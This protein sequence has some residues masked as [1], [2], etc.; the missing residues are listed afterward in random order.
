[1]LNRFKLIGSDIID[2]LGDEDHILTYENVVEILNL[3]SDMLQ[4]LRE[5]NLSLNFVNKKQADFIKS[6]GYTLEQL[7]RFIDG[8]EDECEECP[9]KRSKE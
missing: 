4:K 2:T 5:D 3:Q 8:V 9:K 6:K 1:M 7:I